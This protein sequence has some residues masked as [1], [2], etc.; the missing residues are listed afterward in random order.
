MSPNTSISEQW[1]QKL[2]QEQASIHAEIE[3]I[4]QDLTDIDALLDEDVTPVNIQKPSPVN[5]T[6]PSLPLSDMIAPM[7]MLSSMG[8]DVAMRKAEVSGV[9]KRSVISMDIIIPAYPKYMPVYKKQGSTFTPEEIRDKSGSGIV[10][11]EWPTE[12]NQSMIA[13]KVYTQLQ[14]TIVSGESTVSYRSMRKKWENKMNFYL[15]PNLRYLDKNG[16]S[17]YIPLMRGFE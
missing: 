7:T 4:V 12:S 3:D 5:A 16:K 2:Y 14:E 13:S 11:F 10:M 6:E 17:F 15:V 9:G 1:N 8:S